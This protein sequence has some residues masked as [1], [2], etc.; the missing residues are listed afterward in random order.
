MVVTAAKL[1]FA[2]NAPKTDVATDADLQLSY[3]AVLPRPPRSPVWPSLTSA[4]A[5]CSQLFEKELTWRKRQ[6]M[7]L[8]FQKSDTLFS[9]SELLASNFSFS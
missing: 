4:L 8:A 1:V 9:S 7:P 2:E 6:R 5:F 3:A